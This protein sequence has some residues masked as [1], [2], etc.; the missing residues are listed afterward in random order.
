MA[1][2]MFIIII[3]K[4]PHYF[5][6]GPTFCSNMKRMLQMTYRDKHYQYMWNY[7]QQNAQFPEII[8]L[9]VINEE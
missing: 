9:E 6:K 2:I 4:D 7:K 8:N 5:K 1:C 3:S